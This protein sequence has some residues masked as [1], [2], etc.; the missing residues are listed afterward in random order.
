MF[1]RFVCFFC[2]KSLP[3]DSFLAVVL[4]PMKIGPI[5]SIRIY[6]YRVVGFLMEL[7]A[8]LNASSIM[9]IVIAILMDVS[10]NSPNILPIMP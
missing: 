8:P 6:Q 7:W 3:I 2:Y 9:R 5:N 10:A 1:M 4:I